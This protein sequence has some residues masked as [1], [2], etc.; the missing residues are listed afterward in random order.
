MPKVFIVVLNY[1]DAKT[2]I[3][4]IKMVQKF[5]QI[6][7]VLVVDNASTD[8]SFKRLKQ[9]ESDLIEVIKT[10]K[11]GGY[12]YGNN[13]AIKYLY[14]TY[15]ANYILI[16]NP[17]VIFDENTVM[18]LLEEMKQDKRLAV[19]APIMK[20]GT[21]NRITRNAWPIPSAMEYILSSSVI[22]N[23][24]FHFCQYKKDIFYNK[25]N[26]NVDCV[27]G[28]LLMI[29][30]KH[31]YKYGLYDEKIFLYCEETVLGIKLRKARL[32]TRLVTNCSFIHNHS[33]SISKSIQSEI[34]RK[35]LLLHSKIYV[36][37]EYYKISQ[38]ELFLVRLFFKLVLLE[39]YII[40]KVR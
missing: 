7:K 1:N 13:V 28:C 14:E 23:K 27:S 30:A 6:K 11:N 39:T 38:P 25:S 19:T 32:Y 35:Q 24:L 17:D 21:K 37:K 4:F 33:V 8:N 15:K 16:C 20:E 34:K 18:F 31:I 5:K 26:Q 29:N 40:S 22:L 2:T 10:N 9:Y 3:E 36:L 12:G